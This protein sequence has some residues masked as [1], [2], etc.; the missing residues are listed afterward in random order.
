VDGGSLV[1]LQSRADEIN[2][3]VIGFLIPIFRTDA[4][5]GKKL[6]GLD[7]ESFD[8]VAKG[9]A[10][11]NADCLAEFKTYTIECPVCHY[12]R[13]IAYDIEAAPTHWVQHLEDREEG[14]A[15][16]IA[17]NPFSPDDYFKSIAGDSDIE[18]IK[19]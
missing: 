6:A 2:S 8:K 14:Y 12:V 10:C 18:Q 5:T 15:P 3:V 7:D 4:E 13:D 17:R 9:Y 16:S 19:L 11:A 1:S